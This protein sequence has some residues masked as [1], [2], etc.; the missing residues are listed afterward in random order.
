MI[1][2]SAGGDKEWISLPHK[3]PH[4]S[5]FRK[6]LDRDLSALPWFFVCLFFR[7]FG[8]DNSA[9]YRLG[10][11][12]EYPTECCASASALRPPSGVLQCCPEVS[13]FCIGFFSD[14]AEA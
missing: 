12:E 6:L 14:S 10:F 7:G 8:E 1:F 9:V 4:G 13:R 3:G 11:P 5:D 2:R